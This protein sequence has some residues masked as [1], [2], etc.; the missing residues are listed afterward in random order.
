MAVHRFDR[1]LWPICEM[2]DSVVVHFRLWRL[3]GRAAING[4]CQIPDPAYARLFQL[5]SEEGLA[6]KERV[7]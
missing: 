3:N 2:V 1:R 5:R 6:Y 7:Q 4:G